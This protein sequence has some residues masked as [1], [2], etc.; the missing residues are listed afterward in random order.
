MSDTAHRALSIILFLV[1]IFGLLFTATEAV[2]WSREGTYD[3]VI[4]SAIATVICLCA[5]GVL[6][7]RGFLAGSYT[8]PVD[9][10]WDPSLYE[11][12]YETQTPDSIMPKSIA[13][14]PLRNDDRVYTRRRLVD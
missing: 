14:T 2:T 11:H 9:R 3:L 8:A 7:E 6:F 10:D 1:G 4:L 13:N 5:S 12:E